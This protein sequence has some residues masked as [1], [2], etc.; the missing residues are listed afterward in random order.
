MS[1]TIGILVLALLGALA[2]IVPH[3]ERRIPRLIGLFILVG[4]VVGGFFAWHHYSEEKRA[5]DPWQITTHVLTSDPRPEG[6]GT[7][8]PAQR[9]AYVSG[10]LLG[11]TTADLFERDDTGD[12]N[13]TKFGM[14]SCLQSKDSE[15]LA[16]EFDR[17][18]K[19]RL[20]EQG[21]GES[22]ALN[23]LVQMCPDLK[24][25]MGRERP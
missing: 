20:W 22:D 1:P 11:V 13:R 14:E 7:M 5:V 10:F 18:I 23:I 16:A 24:R 25:K 6:Y 2:Q 15:Q 21:T 4:L 3:K 19:A 8:S 17:Y 12:F 9:D